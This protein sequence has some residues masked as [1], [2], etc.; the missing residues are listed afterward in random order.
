MDK[1]KKEYGD[2]KAKQV[3]Y[4]TENKLRS[5]GKMA[6]MLAKAKKHNDIAK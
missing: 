2:K 4:A 6:G 3:Y 1:M 5:Q